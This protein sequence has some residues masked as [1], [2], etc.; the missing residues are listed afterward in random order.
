MIKQVV[1][2]P[3]KL[4]K[5]YAYRLVELRLGDSLGCRC[6][7]ISK[8]V[9]L[10]FRFIHGLNPG[11]FFHIYLQSFSEILTEDGFR[12]RSLIY[13]TDPNMASFKGEEKLPVQV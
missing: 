5:L 6:A 4:I 3:L 1:V 7:Y 8:C 11:L 13:T 9:I 10:I 12:N 2:E